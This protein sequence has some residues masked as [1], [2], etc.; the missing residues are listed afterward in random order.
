MILVSVSEFFHCLRITQ[1]SGISFN[2]FLSFF[3]FGL[4]HIGI[5][6]GL[7]SMTANPMAWEGSINPKVLSLSL[8]YGYSFTTGFFDKILT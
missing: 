1:T 6:A 7:E 2:F 4:F 8:S 5:G 3:P